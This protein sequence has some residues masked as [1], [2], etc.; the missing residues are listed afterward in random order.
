[1]TGGTTKLSALAFVAASLACGGSPP[2]A[3]PTSSL[4]AQVAEAEP[5]TELA[6]EPAVDAGAGEPATADPEPDTV[7]L[8]S[9]SPE[10]REE[11]RCGSTGGSH[12]LLLELRYDDEARARAFVERMRADGHRVGI[13]GGN[14]ELTVTDAEVERL[15]RTTV[16]YRREP[17]SSRAGWLCSAHLE[18]PRIPRS[19]R[20][21]LRG[22]SVGHQV[23][24]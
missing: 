20:R 7:E 5:T 4:G 14:I 16:T 3:E 10:T 8:P 24:E 6:T 13:V 18:R 12:C 17:R 9:P 15:F 1:M 11:P 21:D 22:V 23:C 2:V 19:Y